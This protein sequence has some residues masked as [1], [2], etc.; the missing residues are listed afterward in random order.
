M[1]TPRKS[2]V[3]AF[4]LLSRMD[5][6]VGQLMEDEGRTMNELIREV[7]RLC[8]EHKEGRGLLSYGQRRA[9]EFG[10]FPEGVERL[11][12]EYRAESSEV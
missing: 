2:K 3:I 11:V 4:S 9:R 1:T 12:D 8:M 6:Q 5:E 7:L 10:I